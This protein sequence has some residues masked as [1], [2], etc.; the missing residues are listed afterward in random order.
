VRAVRDGEPDGAYVQNGRGAVADR[1]CGNGVV[2]DHGGGWTT[3]LCHLRAGS[4]RVRAGQT[5]AAGDVLGL[6]GQSGFAAFPHVHLRMRR[7]G[8][9]VDPITAAP[10]AGAPCR[11]NPPAPGLHW[12]AQ[13]RAQLRYRG[14]ALFASGFSGAAP[15]AD[16]R[17][18]DLPRNAA[19]NAQALVFWALAVGPRNGDVL[20]VRLIGPDGAVVAEGSRTQPR[21]QAQASV[22]GGRRT[23]PSGWAPGAYRGEARLYRNGA[24]IAER[25]ERLVLN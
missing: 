5:I 3:Q 12:T 25:T 23:P 24:V 10:L 13:A 20:R 2:I 8:A 1:E 18:E 9:V 14:T 22:F 4:V 6:V 15:P 7:N 21:D 17:V 11:A 16:A 19:R